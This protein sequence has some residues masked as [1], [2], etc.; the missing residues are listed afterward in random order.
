LL[1]Q[2]ADMALEKFLQSLKGAIH[3]GNTRLIADN[4]YRI[5]QI[6]HYMSNH[7]SLLH[8][9]W[10]NVFAKNQIRSNLDKDNR[11]MADVIKFLNELDKT[12]DWEYMAG[13]FLNE[14]IAIWHQWATDGIRGSARVHP[15]EKIM[16]EGSFLGRITN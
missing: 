4:L 3:L 9:K 16:R 1:D 10:T 7:Q 12:Q 15:F 14:A 8:S 13:Q 2:K 11:I 6:S 5:S